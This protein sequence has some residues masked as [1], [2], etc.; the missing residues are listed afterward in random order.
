MFLYYISINNIHSYLVSAE[1]S[2]VVLH[3][4]QEGVLLKNAFL[5]TDKNP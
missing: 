1:V 3:V 5:K 2:I 4:G